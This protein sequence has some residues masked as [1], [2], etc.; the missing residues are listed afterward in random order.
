MNTSLNIYIC[1]AFIY[2]FVRFGGIFHFISSC[3]RQVIYSK[4]SKTYL[5][6]VTWKH[7]VQVQSN[8]KKTE[9]EKPI[10]GFVV[11]VRDYLALWMLFFLT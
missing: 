3:G 7:S 1:V 6:A 5:R 10:Y 2:L 9:I 4:Q 8:N 11:I